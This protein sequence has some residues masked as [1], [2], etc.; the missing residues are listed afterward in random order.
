[1]EWRSRLLFWLQGLIIF[2]SSIIFS[3]YQVYSANHAMQIPYVQW[4][5][6][7]SLFPNDP[8]VSTF[9]HYIGPVWQVVAIISKFIPLEPLL[10]ILFLVT[11]A[12]ILVA[13]ARL[14]MTLNPGSRL[15]AVGAMA[16]FA[17]S[18]SPLIGHGTIVINYF[19]HT[20]LSIAFL[21]LATAAFYS[22]RPFYWA[23]WFAIGFNLNI[24][25]GTYACVYFAAL[26]F[27]DAHYRSRWKNWLLASF[28]F[29]VLALPTI[30][31]TASAFRIDAV[32]KQLW[33]RASEVRHP[34]HMY[35]LTWRPQQFYVFF[36][37]ILCFVLTL[38][39]GKRVMSR[40]YTHGMI[41]L[42]V[43]L[44]WLSFA[45]FAA[46]VVKAPAMLVMQPARGTDLWFAFAV[47]A[48]IAIF[49]YLNNDKT[50]HKRLYV[51]FFFFS[52]MWLNFFYF[53]LITIY[54]WAFIAVGVFWNPAWK[55]ILKHGDAVRLSNIVV[56]VILFF[57][58]FRISSL[59][60]AG[61][62]GDI[63]DLP[64]SQM[65]EIA[66]WARENTS[67]EDMFLVDPHWE[68]FRALSQRPVFVAWKDGT[69]ILWE[70]S[71]VGEWVT[72]IESFGFNFINADE[73]GTTKG[74]S[75]LSYLYEDMDDEDVTMLLGNYPISFWVVPID[76]PSSLP[77]VFQ[78]ARYKVLDLKNKT[79]GR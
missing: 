52:F 73:L 77:I 8:F 60:K 58:V 70:R 47:I 61:A 5:N 35:P 42:A 57:A 6:D 46:Y 21:L 56:L 49:A 55:F 20:S 66:D 37:F 63:I 39:R 62:I 16:F 64:D 29:I 4:I 12:L 43:S 36:G 72:R 24:L 79:E 25:Y 34:F 68:E 67:S 14:A 59:A 41:W 9:V 15:A 1:M 50:H 45:F 28:I 75:Q 53:S 26:F 76:H 69:A 78:T 65:M 10:L 23:L 40:L 48:M 7:P 13:A 38:Y 22:K 18:P 71:F 33:L 31:P 17:L 27:L 19:E 54:I 74:S 32:N 51:V 11:R 30:V 3:G 44:F 2:L